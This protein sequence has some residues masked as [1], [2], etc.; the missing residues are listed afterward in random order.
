MHQKQSEEMV[1]EKEIIYISKVAERTSKLHQQYLI[2]G[3]S[4][5]NPISNIGSYP[6]GPK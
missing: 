4:G 6:G 1:Y 3:N 2:L 5:K